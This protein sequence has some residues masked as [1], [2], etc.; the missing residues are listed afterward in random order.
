MYKEYGELIA[1]VL[2]GEFNHDATREHL[3]GGSRI[4]GSFAAED[5]ALVKD[6]I[7]GARAL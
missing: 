3:I 4:A 5:A 1:N 7:V 2:Y 6:G